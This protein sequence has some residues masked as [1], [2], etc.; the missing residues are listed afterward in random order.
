MRPT[1]ALKDWRRFGKQSPLA[2]TPQLRAKLRDEAVKFLVLREVEAQMPELATGGTHGLVFGPTGHRLAVLSEDD[3]ELT[4]W[5]VVH[6]QRRGSPHS[7][8]IGPGSAG[9]PRREP[10]E[11][12]RQWRSPR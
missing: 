2:P 3:E 11:R 12:K 5:D 9:D 8:R 1:A 7:L 4:F 10:A 6:Q